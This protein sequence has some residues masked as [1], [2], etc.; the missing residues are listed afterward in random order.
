MHLSEGRDIVVQ[1]LEHI[2]GSNQINRAGGEGQFLCCAQTNIDQST[3]VTIPNGFLI[4]V[5]ALRF[6]ICGEVGQ[7]RSGSATNVEDPPP[8]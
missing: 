2:E 8:F 1:V 5:D 7:H 3:L 6:A 4:D